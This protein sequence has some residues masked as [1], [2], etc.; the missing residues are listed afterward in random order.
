MCTVTKHAATTESPNQ[1]A[2]YSCPIWKW[3]LAPFWDGCKHRFQKFYLNCLHTRMQQSLHSHG[4]TAWFIFHVIRSVT[5]TVLPQGN[6]VLY[7]S[8]II[9]SLNLKME[10]CKQLISR[11]RMRQV[12]DRCV[13]GSRS[14]EAVKLGLVKAE[15]PSLEAFRARVDGAYGQPDL[16]AR[17]G[18]RLRSLSNPRFSRIL[19]N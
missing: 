15:S 11:E 18:T 3:L 4:H 17:R 6:Q 1:V 9:F 10:G 5:D 13:F 8:S 7:V 2:A 19:W 16:V 14:G 12:D